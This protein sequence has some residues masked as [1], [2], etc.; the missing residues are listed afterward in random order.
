V[1][2]GS[3]LLCSIWVPQGLDM[4][5][6]G[7]HLTRQW[8][9]ISHPSSIDVGVAWL[10]DMIGGTWL[11]IVDGL[12]L[13]GARLGWAV[14]IAITSWILFAILRRSFKPTPSAVAV[15]LAG[16]AVNYGGDLVLDYN[17]I[18]AALLLLAIYFLLPVRA[19]QRASSAQHDWRGILGGI[20]LGASVL[21]RLPLVL[22]LPLPVLMA[23][24]GPRDSKRALLRSLLP[25]LTAVGAIACGLLLLAAR[26]Q[27]AGYLN[28]IHSTLLAPAADSTHAPSYLLTLYL[29][30]AGT[31]AVHGF[32]LVA[33]LIGPALLSYALTKWT[34]WR[35]LHIVPIAAVAVLGIYLL[36]DLPG[37]IWDYGLAMPGFFIVMAA[38]ECVVLAISGKRGTA[39]LRRV[40]LLITGVAIAVLAMIGS[41]NGVSN[42]RHGLH[43]LIPAVCLG[44]PDALE[45]VMDLIKRV[46]RAGG[47]PASLQGGYPTLLSLLL[48][49][50]LAVGFS[51]NSVLF[52]YNDPYRD[53]SDRS[54]LRCAIESPLLQG[55]L[56]SEQRA[57]ST[58]A[59]I[60]Q[61]KTLTNAGDTILA[62]N[63]IPLVYYVTQTIPA[64]DTPWPILHSADDLRV[65]LD[66]LSRQDLPVVLVRATAN[67]RGRNWGAEVTY[68]ANPTSLERLAVIDQWVAG[69]GYN[70][71][72]QNRDFRIYVLDGGTRN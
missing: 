44:L 10:S 71:V 51:T 60:E 39:Q 61:L 29:R 63:S 30:Q 68:V 43:L 64:L 53:S 66:D 8:L 3:F 22:A 33:L 42:M 52:R 47:L 72:W 35:F 21:A 32:R 50:A 40:Q 54:A 28:A 25:I 31:A 12:G 18:P 62:Y 2:V 49:V 70:V 5:D 67:T 11:K 6:E 17:K 55:V 45:G 24:V 19:G 9:I 38:V 13:L 20:I 23:I 41:N 26:G 59:M 56:T 16:L 58:E 34:R 36:S 7:Y 27:L 65:E 69:H 48:P 46:L 37:G 4:T 57:A 14:V 1:L 15:I